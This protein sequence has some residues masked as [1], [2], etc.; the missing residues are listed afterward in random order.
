MRRLDGHDGPVYALAFT[1]DGQS[2]AS[3]GKDGLVQLIDLTTKRRIRLA[4]LN[5]VSH[6]VCHALAAHSNG[7]MLAVGTANGVTF[8]DTETNTA[9][10]VPPKVPA[11]VTSLA[12]LD[13]GRLLAVGLGDRMDPKVPGDCAHE[14]NRAVR[15][16]M[17]MSTTVAALATQPGGKRIAFGSGDRRIGRW[18]VTSPDRRATPA[19]SRPARAVTLNPGG[20]H[21][22]AADDYAINIYDAESMQRGA[23]SRPHRA[24][25]CSRL[26]ARR[27]VIVVRAD[28]TV[29]M[30]CGIGPR[31]WRPRLGHRR[32]PS[33]G[34][35]VRRPPGRCGRRPW[36]NRH[37]GS[38][39]LTRL[40]QFR[41]HKVR[42][43]GIYTPL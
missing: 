10:M 19:Q 24:R 39:R 18:D 21:I 30:G 27:Q 34:H 25:G 7:V 13:H 15:Q 22:A 2:L 35:I 28:H 33:R 11:E 20:T 8:W 43:S 37:L 1:A 29:H 4:S 26:H 40:R 17:S 14:R 42:R 9:R 12:Y 23:A 32:R 38:G 3:G 6:Q 31:A 41:G 36:H 5:A 16:Q